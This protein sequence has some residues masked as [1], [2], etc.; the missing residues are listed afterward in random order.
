LKIRIPENSWIDQR[1]ISICYY[2]LIDETKVKPVV[3]ELFIT[4]FKWIDVKDLPALLFDNKF[5]IEKAIKHLQNDLNSN[6]IAHYL[7]I[8]PF[9]MNEL[10]SLY[11]VVFQK[12]FARNNFQRKMLNLGIL[13]R[14]EK[15]FNGKSHKA[16]FLYQFKSNLSS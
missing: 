1:Y 15:R 11:E 7:L 3:Q 5:I 13:E 4:E 12:K 9:T 10:Q 2:A 14:L 8:K 16:P 6:L